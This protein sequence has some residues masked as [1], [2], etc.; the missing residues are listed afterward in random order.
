MTCVIL[1]DDV[2]M[3]FTVTHEALKVVVTHPLLS[4]TLYFYITVHHIRKLF[5]RVPYAHH[6]IVGIQKYTK[7]YKSIQKY[8]KI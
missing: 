2:A 6:E 8:T 3:V 5:G 1:R 7:V 4:E